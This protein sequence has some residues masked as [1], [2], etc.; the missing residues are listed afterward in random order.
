MVLRIVCGFYAYKC[1][2]FRWTTVNGGNGKW[3]RK[4]ETANDRHYKSINLVH[5]KL[6]RIGAS[7]RV[8]IHGLV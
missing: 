2:N 1:P 5:D 3:K 8:Q 7:L 6:G 4:V